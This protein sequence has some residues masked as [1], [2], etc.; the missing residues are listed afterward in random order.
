MVGNKSK[1]TNKNTQAAESA[2]LSIDCFNEDFNRPPA[3]DL[4][5]RKL[6]VS[7][8]ASQHVGHKQTACSSDDSTRQSACSNSSAEKEI[9]VVSNSTESILDQ[10]LKSQEELAQLQSHVKVLEESAK[11]TPKSAVLDKDDSFSNS[12]PR[13]RKRE[14]MELVSNETVPEEWTQVKEKG[15][16]A[17]EMKQLVA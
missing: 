11:S 9:P 13:K 5:R 15:L 14:T 10:L 17:L 12:N 3:Q 2:S 4:K 1:R 16:Q 6:S 7:Q 8:S